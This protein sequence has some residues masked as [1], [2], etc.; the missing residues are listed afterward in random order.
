MLTVHVSQEKQAD[1]QIFK[2]LEVDSENYMMG[3]RGKLRGTHMEREL[4][5]K[6]VGGM[7]L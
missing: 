5:S 6:A 7:E 2:I 3:H 1:G 4:S